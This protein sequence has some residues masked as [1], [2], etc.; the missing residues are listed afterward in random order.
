VKKRIVRGLAVAL[1]GGASAGCF[2]QAEMTSPET[3]KV[4]TAGRTGCQPEQITVS[5]DRINIHLRSW[6]AECGGRRYV[7]SGGAGVSLA[8]SE[9][10]P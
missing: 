6:N 4:I 8:C 3:L 9:R 2:G 1:L 5:N 10:V 7:C